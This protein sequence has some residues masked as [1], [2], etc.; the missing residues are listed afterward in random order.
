MRMN[1]TGVL[2][3][4]LLAAGLAACSSVPLPSEQL[5]TADQAVSKLDQAS[6]PLDA[7][8]NVSNARDKLATAKEAVTAK[9]YLKARNLAEQAQADAELALAKSDSAKAKAAVEELRQSISS[10][11]SEISRNKGVR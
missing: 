2:A 1:G 9:D 4:S 10:L 7:Q 5:K 3:A 6:I 8:V 11:Q